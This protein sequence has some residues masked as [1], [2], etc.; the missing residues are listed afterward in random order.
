MKLYTKPSVSQLE[1]KGKVDV[2]F[3]LSDSETFEQGTAALRV[4]VPSPEAQAKYG[5]PPFPFA[6]SW[7]HPNADRDENGIN[8]LPKI[9]ANFKQDFEGA[10]TLLSVISGLHRGQWTSVSKDM[11]TTA[12]YAFV[13]RSAIIVPQKDEGDETK[14]LKK[15]ATRPMNSLKKS[16]RN[17]TAQK[18]YAAELCGEGTMIVC[19]GK[20]RLEDIPNGSWVILERMPHSYAL[21]SVAVDGQHMLY[22]KL[23]EVVIGKRDVY[24]KGFDRKT[25]WAQ[26][27]SDALADPDLRK[28]CWVDPQTGTM[29]YFKFMPLISKMLDTLGM[30]PE[31]AQAEVKASSKASKMSAAIRA[32]NLRVVNARQAETELTGAPYEVN[33]PDGTLLLVDAIWS[34]SPAGVQKMAD[35]PEAFVTLE[36]GV[37]VNPA[38][39]PENAHYKAFNYDGYAIGKWLLAPD[40]VDQYGHAK[41]AVAVS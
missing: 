25:S 36:E 1:G 29:L 3:T 37:F 4:R 18:T 39:L 17:T 41:M 26:D 20:L 9:V 23:V 27:V 34:K 28:W 7:Y 19:K 24:L 21:T 16:D 15:V 14:G 11:I 33:V 8:T 2:D 35:F 6:V 40:F 10:K 30:T 38:L 32:E 12:N 5:L 31:C 13:Q 22:E